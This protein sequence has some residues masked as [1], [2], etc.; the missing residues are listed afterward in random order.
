MLANVIERQSPEKVD[1]DFH[2]CHKLNDFHHSHHLHKIQAK[3]DTDSNNFTS[4]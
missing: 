4:P 2:H 1:N 3:Y